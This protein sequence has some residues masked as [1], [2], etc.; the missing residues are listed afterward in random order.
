[1]STFT[2]KLVT[3]ILSIMG[4]I[5]MIFHQIG[6][7]LILLLSIAMINATKLIGGM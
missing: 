1:M 6:I 5:C 3:V 2:I 4:V 7:L